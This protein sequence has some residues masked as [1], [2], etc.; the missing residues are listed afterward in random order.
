[1]EEFVLAAIEQ[2][3]TGYGI[4]SHA[5]LPFPT[6]WTMDA[7]QMDEYLA[8]IG[9]LKAKYHSRIDIYAGLE[10]D[11][12]DA[13]HNPASDYFQQLPLD[14]RIGSVHL[15]EGD[16]GEFVDIDTNRE[17]FAQNID[18]HFHGNIRHAVLAYYDKLTRM[19][20]AGGFDI[21]GHA[22]KMSYNA[23]G[24]QSGITAQTWYEDRVGDYFDLIA[25]KGIMVE[26]NTKM[27]SRIGRFFPHQCYFGR[28]RELG[29]PVVVN[30]DA[31]YPE[32]ID[33]GRRQALA[34][35]REAGF[36]TVRELEGGLWKDIPIEI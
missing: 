13:V 28:L 31:H 21:L 22:D 19:I 32:L 29:I 12:L 33:S 18:T 30:S 25:R 24:Y 20:E 3:F 10:I 14:Y 4:S 15:L 2:G 36:Q 26:I 6:R 34:L 23:E 16:G 5:P 27:F 9:R 7:S 35:L 8:E 1:M 17:I 11:Y